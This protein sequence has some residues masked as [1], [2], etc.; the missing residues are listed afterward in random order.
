MSDRA[1]EADNRIEQRNE[2]LKDIFYPDMAEKDQLFEVLAV[3]HSVFSLSK[4]ETDLIKLHIDT[5]DATP[6]KYRLQ[7]MHDAGVL[8]PSNSPW[9]SP[10]VLVQKKNEILSFF[11]YYS[12]LNSVTKLDHLLDQLGES[13]FFTSIWILA[14]TH[15]QGV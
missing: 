3:H 7:K 11:V 8:E 15:G 4:E 9:A 2:K 6:R 12:G 5:G 1:C 13:K 14:D 10:V